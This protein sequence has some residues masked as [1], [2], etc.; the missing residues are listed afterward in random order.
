MRVN[1]YGEE[2]TT[3]VELVKK[4]VNQNTF[5]G[6]RLYLKSHEDLHHSEPDNDESAITIWAPWTNKKKSDLFLLQNIL[7][8]MINLVYG[9][10]HEQRDNG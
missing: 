8:M 2:L 6:I 10:I 5:Y 7:A 9:E 1:I 3:K 4:A